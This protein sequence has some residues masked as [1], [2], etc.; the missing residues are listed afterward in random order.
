MIQGLLVKKKDKQEIINYL[1][2]KRFWGRWLPENKDDYS[3]L[4]NREKFWSPAY[5]EQ[6]AENIWKTI[7]NTKYEVIVSTESAKGIFDRDSSGANQPYNIPCR[8]IFEGMKLKYT[9][10]DCGLSLDEGKTIV[11]NT[12]PDSVLIRKKELI[13]F[14]DQNDLDII[15]TLVGEKFLYIKNKQ[16]EWYLAEL[17]GLFYLEE[18]NVK[19][20]FFKLYN[21]E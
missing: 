18:N 6:Y 4:I 2:E 14:L 12:K 13:N 11:I 5:K 7:D 21:R 8:Y 3:S 17:E 15:W 10:F 20:E 19:K 16:E 9:T 1:K